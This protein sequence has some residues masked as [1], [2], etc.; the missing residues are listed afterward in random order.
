MFNNYPVASAFHWTRRIVN[1]T[2]WRI[3]YWGYSNPYYSSGSYYAESGSGNYSYQ[4]PL[5]EYADPAEAPA[6]GAASEEVAYPPGVTTEGMDAFDAARSA[7]YE[8]DY[9][10]ASEHVNET[11]KTMPND[12]VVHEFRSLV[13]FA[14]QQFDESAAAN[15]AVLAVGPGWDWT[16]MSSL[17]GNVDDYTSQLRALE[18]YVQS[19]PDSSSGHFLLA[20]HYATADHEDAAAAQ[21]KQVLQL[22]PQ[23]DVALDQLSQLEGAEAI[24][25]FTSL[26]QG[27]DTAASETAPDLPVDQLE[28]T[29]A[30]Q[31]GNATFEMTLTA[32]GGF[33]W[34]FKQ[35]EKS[36]SVG[37]VYAVDNNVL[38][39]ELDSDD[40]LAA[41]ISNLTATSMDFLLVSYDPN[42]EPMK[43]QKR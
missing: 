41:E 27:S 38:A 29:W 31:K 35:G 42:E 28:G 8:G 37:G 32:D 21:Y 2:A 26:P 15:Y 13:L 39:V 40:T 17:Y 18:D 23:N 10:L 11:L 43:F 7:F 36:E 24:A 30:G 20:Y 3:G 4:E 34:A 19:N 25:E 33:T 9:Q 16:T 14:L 5:V 12:A 1:R 6:E 22:N